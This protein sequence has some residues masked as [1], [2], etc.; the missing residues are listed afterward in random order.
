MGIGLSATLE[1]MMFAA[2]ESLVCEASSHEA[3]M[4]SPSLARVCRGLYKD[5]F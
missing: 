4:V 1:L 5:C 2:D 3:T